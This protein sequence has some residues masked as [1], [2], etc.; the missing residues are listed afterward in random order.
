MTLVDARP[1]AQIAAWDAL[2]QEAVTLVMRE[3]AEQYPVF[4][5]ATALQQLQCS[6][7]ETRCRPVGAP[8][9]SGRAMRCLSQ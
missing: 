5:V 7:L 2:S 3:A 8:L 9:Q 4:L 1:L 6:F